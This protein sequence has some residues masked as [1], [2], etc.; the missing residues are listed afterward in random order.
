MFRYL[1]GLSSIHRHQRSDLALARYLTFVAGA[2]NAGGFL[3]TK[4]YT[5][6]MSGLVATMADFLVLA[7]YDVVLTALGA[8][9]SFVLGAATTALMVNWARRSQL[10]SRYALPLLLEAALLLLF[11]LVGRKLAA[12]S[13]EFVS[14]TIVLL[15]YLMGLQNALI[16]KISSARIRTTHVT[17]MVTDIGIELGRLLY[18]NRGNDSDKAAGE[19]VVADLQNLKMLLGLVSLFFIGGVVGAAG[20]SRFGFLFSIPL[21]LLVAF[22]AVVPAWDDVSNWYRLRKT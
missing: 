6:H 22:V 12:T 1:R 4:I 13:F 21:A 7:K 19:R 15:G 9:V 16:T 14:S 20:F 18:W 17:G 11:A 10:E 2:T 5:S 3:A 8:I